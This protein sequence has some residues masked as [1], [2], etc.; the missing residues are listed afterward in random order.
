MERIEYDP[1]LAL[2]AVFDGASHIPAPGGLRFS[3]GPIAWMADN[4]QKGISPDAHTVTIHATPDY[5]RQHWRSN[6]IVVA[7]KLLE[8]A[9]LWLH[10]EVLD[11]QIHRWR[12]SQPVTK[13]PEQALFLP[14]PPPLVFAGDAFGGPRVEG[15][16]LSGYA[17]AQTLLTARDR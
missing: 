16:A 17:A 7:Q 14:G 6:A 15:A 13:C 9:A 5:S 12:Y 4:H 2:L 3:E 11:L 10:P 8:A 1:C